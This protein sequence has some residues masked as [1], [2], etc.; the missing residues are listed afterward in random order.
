MSARGFI[1]VP[2]VALPLLI[3]VTGATAEQFDLQAPP[4]GPGDRAKVAPRNPPARPHRPEPDI[5]P[6]RPPVP[7]APGFIEPLTKETATGRLGIAGWT[8]PNTPV[9][10]RGA[11]D[12]DNAGWPA[13]GLGMEWGGPK[14]SVV[15]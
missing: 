9:G 6:Q 11:T 13:M 2:V 4:A 8:S 14:K 5:Y 10:S 1:T 12:P 7:Y 3:V 15:R